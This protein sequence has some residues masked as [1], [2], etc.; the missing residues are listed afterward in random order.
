MQKEQ[1][2][3]DYH[4]L[5]FSVMVERDCDLQTAID[6]STDMMRTRVEEY[7]GHKTQLPVFGDEVDA[8]VTKYPQGLEHYVQGCIVWNHVSQPSY[9]FTVDGWWWC[10]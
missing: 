10:Y 2:D 7:L 5:V 6:I 1:A 4:N 3:G 8:E 9:V